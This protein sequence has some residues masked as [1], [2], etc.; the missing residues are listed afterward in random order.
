MSPA[1][2]L[3]VGVYPGGMV[4]A[5]RAR[6]QHGDYARVAFLPWH[7]LTLQVEPGADAALVALA[8]ASAAKLQAKRGELYPLSATA[9]R[10]ANGNLTGSQCVRLGA[11]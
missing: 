6:E 2:R 1:D 5:D 10:D 9:D 3:F 7:S 11:A 4:Y 8:R